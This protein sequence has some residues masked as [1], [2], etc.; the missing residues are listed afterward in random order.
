MEF[1]REVLG[2]DEVFAAGPLDD[3]RD[4]L[5][6]G[7]VDDRGGDALAGTDVGGDLVAFL[8]NLDQLQQIAVVGIPTGADIS[9][10]DDGIEVFLSHFTFFAGFRVNKNTGCCVIGTDCNGGLIFAFIYTN[11][12]ANTVSAVFGLTGSYSACYAYRTGRRAG[13]TRPDFDTIAA[14]ALI[15]V[16]AAACDTAA[17][18]NGSAATYN[19]TITGVMLIVIVV[20][21]A[22]AQSRSIEMSRR[23]RLLSRTAVNAA[24][25]G[26][27]A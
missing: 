24:E 9:D 22:L 11:V 13:S 23:K 12:D 27:K 10:C 1:F 20:I 14:R 6:A 21:D 4:A 26:L 8:G 25:G 3:Q 2:N 17:H 16:G 5:V 18:R 15:A 19:N 7:S